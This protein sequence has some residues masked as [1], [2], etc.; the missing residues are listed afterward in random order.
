MKNI[1]MKLF[2]NRIIRVDYRK[3]KVLSYYNDLLL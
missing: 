2:K 1:L 3:D